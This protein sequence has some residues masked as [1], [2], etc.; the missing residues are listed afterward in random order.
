MTKTKGE[1]REEQRRKNQH[2]MKVNGQSM[3]RLLVERAAQAQKGT[4]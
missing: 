1:R 3:K 2:G 4:K